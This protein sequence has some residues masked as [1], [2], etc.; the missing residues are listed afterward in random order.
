MDSRTAARS[1]IWVFIGNSF[2]AG[3]LTP[4]GYL[5]ALGGARGGEQKGSL[6]ELRAETPSAART[7]PRLRP[8]SGRAGSG[9]TRGRRRARLRGCRTPAPAKRAAAKRERGD[10]GRTS[11]LP[12][13]GVAAIG[14][15]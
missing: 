11:E 2:G 8:P 1:V 12:I 7:A 13:L 9:G 4:M 14:E 10:G 5:G 15:S 6:R 3:L